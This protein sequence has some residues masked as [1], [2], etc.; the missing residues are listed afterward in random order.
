M[1]E[2]KEFV[3]NAAGYIRKYLAGL[4]EKT[5]AGLFTG[6]ESGGHPRRGCPPWKILIVFPLFQ[7]CLKL[8]KRLFQDGGGAG[9]VDALESLAA[10]AEDFAEIGRAHV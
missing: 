3:A 4:S 10:G 1:G 9:D 8:T 6:G 2:K 7:G 5:Q